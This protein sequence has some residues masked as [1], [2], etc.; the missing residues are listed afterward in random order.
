MLEL[1]VRRGTLIHIMRNLLA[2]PYV[3][4]TILVAITTSSVRKKKEPRLSADVLTQHVQE[5]SELLMQPWFCVKRLEML[6]K[7][8]EMLV[9]AMQK[10]SEYL[11]GKNANMQKHHQSI[12]PCQ[13]TD[14][15]R[16]PVCSG[17]VH[18]YYADLE[19]SCRYL[20]HE[21]FSMNMFLKIS[22]DIEPGWQI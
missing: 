12:E 8:V 15:T 16:L 21:Y 17:L 10:Y 7:E 19:E 6:R 13:L 9:D 4:L 1:L 3:Y 2:V 20:P 14:N 18:A 11:N 22:T 5:L